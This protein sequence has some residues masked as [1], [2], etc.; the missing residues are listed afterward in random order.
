MCSATTRQG[1]GRWPNV[2]RP[3][4]PEPMPTITRSAPARSTSV[5]I[6]AAVVIGWRSDGTVTP[7]PR[8]MRSVRSAARHSCTHTS[9]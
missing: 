7:G 2:I 9:V 1:S 5:A 3:V 6:A 8:A 4:N